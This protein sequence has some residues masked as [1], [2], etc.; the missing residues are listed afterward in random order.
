MSKR[1]ISTG[2]VPT[3]VATSSDLPVAA[4]QALQASLNR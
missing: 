3:T 4:H 2:G 1:V